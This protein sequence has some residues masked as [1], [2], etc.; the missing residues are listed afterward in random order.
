MNDD[1]L[2]VDGIQPSIIYL[3]IFGEKW[4]QK[5]YIYII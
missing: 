4:L 5:N 3:H 2:S 1:I